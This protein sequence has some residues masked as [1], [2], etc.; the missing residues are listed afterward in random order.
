MP[1]V[2][3]ICSDAEVKSTERALDKKAKSLLTFAICQHQL[4]FGG[5]KN[6]FWK[7]NEQTSG[8][9]GFDTDG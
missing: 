2:H 7:P 5:W 4:C 1:V 9:K 8:H 6:L 3:W